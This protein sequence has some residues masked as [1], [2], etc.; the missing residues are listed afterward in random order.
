MKPKEYLAL[1]TLDSRFPSSPISGFGR[2]AA[3]EA[4]AVTGA[5]ATAA[6]ATAAAATAAAAVGAA[7]TAGVSVCDSKEY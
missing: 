2:E 3:V 6:A 1:E 7:A 5:A 4:S